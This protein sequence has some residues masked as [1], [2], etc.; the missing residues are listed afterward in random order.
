[1]RWRDRESSV[2][3]PPAELLEFDPRQWPGTLYEATWAWMEAVQLWIDTYG[4]E[5]W[6]GGRAARSAANHRANVLSDEPFD[7]DEL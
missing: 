7:P 4:I 6:P 3:E 1:M 2:P 5:E